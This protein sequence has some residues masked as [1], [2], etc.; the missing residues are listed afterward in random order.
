MIPVSMSDYLSMKAF[1][2]GL[3]ATIIND[4]PYMAWWDSPWNPD[5][6]TDE[7]N[8][9]DIGTAAHSVLLEG[10]EDCL[11][12]IDPQEHRSKPTKADPEGSIPSGWTNAAMREAK[13]AAYAAGK[14]PILPARRAGILSM[15]A[16]A[17]E[18]ISRTELAGIFDDG[19]SEHTFTWV[20]NGVPCKIRPDRLSADRRV[21]LSYKTTPGSANPRR[22]IRTQLPGYEI[23][24]PLYERGIRACCFVEQARVIHL[25]Q[26]QEPPYACSLVGLAPSR[27]DLAERQLDAALSI[28]R[29]CLQTKRFPA[30][31]TQICY[32]EVVGWQAAA[33][34]E[35]HGE[36]EISKTLEAMGA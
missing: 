30:Y 22:W 13:A 25:V 18:F 32:A 35:E 29:E 20:E 36:D 9:S 34:E 5:R 21:I 8:A 10:S 14:T 7:S 27:Q 1:S 4:S 19:D 28:W 33:F 6:R 2:A 12:V 23:G 16:A 26:S 15:V 31:P 17:R 3:A 11:A 24:M